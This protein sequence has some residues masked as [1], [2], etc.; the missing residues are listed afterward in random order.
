MLSA[1]DAACKVKALHG[2]HTKRIKTGRNQHIAPYIRKSIFP[3]SVNKKVA[4]QWG[5]LHPAK[6]L[7]I[8]ALAVGIPL[9]LYFLG[10]SLK[11]LNGERIEVLGIT[12]RDTGKRP[13][14]SSSEPETTYERQKADSSE[15][16]AK[17]P[18]PCTHLSGTQEGVACM[19]GIGFIVVGQNY[20]KHESND[21]NGVEFQ[22]AK[23]SGS[24]IYGKYMDC[25][26][27]ILYNRTHSGSIGG[28]LPQNSNGLGTYVCKMY[29]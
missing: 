18:N 14:E 10:E 26:N 1:I 5:R 19:N 15:L 29:F 28:G 2:I 27:G 24:N 16:T 17:F 7:G 11:N 3:V 4:H 21:P 13:T 8:I 23:S 22:W 25:K 6:F 20:I 12:I 9:S